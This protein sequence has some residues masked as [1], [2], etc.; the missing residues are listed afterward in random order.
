M[1]VAALL[2]L[3]AGCRRGGATT[4]G[5]TG[6]DAGSLPE[7][8]IAAVAGTARSAWALADTSVE[9]DNRRL[10]HW[11]GCSWS[12]APS[13]ITAARVRRLSAVW[14]D[15]AAVFLAGEGLVFRR[16]AEG[17]W[18]AIGE[19]TGGEVDLISGR[20]PGDLWMLEGGPTGRHQVLHWNGTR[21][22]V[23]HVDGLPAP[24]TLWTNGPGDVWVAGGDSVARREGDGWRRFKIDDQAFLNFGAGTGPRHAWVAGPDRV[25]RW[26]GD[27]WE[28]AES[29]GVQALWKLGVFEEGVFAVTA[30]GEISV[31]HGNVWSPIGYL[32]PWQHPAQRGRKYA[33]AFPVGGELWAVTGDDT[34]L[35]HVMRRHDGRWSPLGPHATPPNAENSVALWADQSGTVW[36]A[37]AFRAGFPPSP[38][39][40]IRRFDAGTGT[41]VRAAALEQFPTALHGTAPDDVWAVGFGGAA[42]HWNGTRW[43]SVPTGGRDNLYAVW[44]SRHDDVW[45]AG[46]WG[47][48][49]NWDGASWR[50]WTTF[51]LTTPARPLRALSGTGSKDAWAVGQNHVFHWDG[52]G[53][54]AR[55]EGD[56]AIAWSLGTG[57]LSALYAAS[58]SDVWAVGTGGETEPINGGIKAG[59]GWRALPRPLILRWDG[60]AWSRLSGPGKNPAASA[61]RAIAGVSS[62]N[63]WA[64][65]DD[66]TILRWDGRLWS[67]VTSPLNEDLRSVAVTPDGHV[68]IGGVDGTLRRLD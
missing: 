60:H 42:W 21:I 14:S 3:V 61:L 58:P 65:G 56:P 12:E 66:G 29:F 31:A 34:T 45:A 57:L 49:Y 4:C 64:V 30:R 22:A 68:F 48:L 46:D 55:T 15:G 27:S 67:Q 9:G 50:R 59:G 37:L 13:P 53:W 43:R 62:T 54:S 63:V 39:G 25:W 1:G 38:S 26:D 24:S 44:G 19:R 2:L 41:W 23:E 10:L 51:G 32:R 47:A 8:T 52:R 7:V 35:E 36:A 5:P 17:V 16:T 40:E 33:Q 20:G 28:A 6:G 11:D 18:Q